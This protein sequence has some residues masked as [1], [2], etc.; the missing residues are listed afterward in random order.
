MTAAMHNNK[1]II[2]EKIVCLTISNFMLSFLLSLIIDLYS[3]IPLTA[4]A[5]ITGIII[6]FCKNILYTIFVTKSHNEL[7]D[8]SFR[9]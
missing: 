7:H 4:K 9:L 8:L 3:L 6:I 5:I 1:S 2:T